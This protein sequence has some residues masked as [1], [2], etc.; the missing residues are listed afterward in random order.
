M[1]KNKKQQGFEFIIEESDVLERENFG[2][3]EIAICKGGCVFRNYTGYRVFTTPYA[4]G[5]D[6]K[7]HDTSL[8]AWLKYMVEFKKSIVGK[9]NGKYADTDV[10]NQEMLDGLKIATEAN[11]I[12]PMVVFTDFEEAQREALR[13]QEW[14]VKQMQDLQKAM[15]TDPP[16]EDVKANA[17][18][19]HMAINAEEVEDLWDGWKNQNCD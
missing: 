17:E 7:A 1:A 5:V 9:E 13:Y 16:E 18:F 3:F 4:V 11:L 8:Y 19:E 14:F 10:T 12:K 6:G 15:E 2:S